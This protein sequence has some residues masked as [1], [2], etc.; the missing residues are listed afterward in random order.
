MTSNIL[1]L[2]KHSQQIKPH[3][4]IDVVYIHLLK[5]QLRGGFIAFNSSHPSLL[6]HV[7]GHSPAYESLN[8]FQTIKNVFPLKPASSQQVAVKRNVNLRFMP[9]L[10]RKWASRDR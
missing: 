3:L 9:Y 6:L 10:A 4:L 1:L 2:D 5:L 7:G 8:T